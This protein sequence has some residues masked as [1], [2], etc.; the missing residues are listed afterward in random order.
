MMQ[1]DYTRKTQAIAEERKYYDNLQA[2][3]DSVKRDPR[4]AEN[5][6]S[7]Y[8]K[9]FHN[10]LGYVSSGSQQAQGAPQ[11]QQQQQSGY[12]A[13]LENRFKRMESYYQTQTTQAAEAH[14]ESMC[15]K[16]GEK[17]S[18]VKGPYESL[19]LGMLSTRLDQLKKEDPEAKLS[20]SD[21]NTAYKQVHEHN[22]KLAKELYSKQVNQQKTING[23]AKDVASGGGTPGQAPKLPRNIKE[24]SDLARQDPNFQ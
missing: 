1:S 20:E 3:L 23:R 21:W 12:S 16:F 4:L 11:E 9:K 22:Q 17:Y 7:I 14:V 15:Q 5:F 13:D 8:P 6:K 18:T 10:Y 2:D 24:A 19:A